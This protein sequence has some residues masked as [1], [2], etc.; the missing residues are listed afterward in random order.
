MIHTSLPFFIQE[1]NLIYVIGSTSLFII[2]KN[3]LQKCY[4]LFQKINTESCLKKYF[5][6]QK[7][8][9]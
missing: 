8:K 4:T 6:Y 2:K 5:Q 3:T 9:N 1:K 7:E